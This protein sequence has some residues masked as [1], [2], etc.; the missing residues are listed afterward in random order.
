[1]PEMFANAIG[2]EQLMGRWSVRLAPLYADFAR[3]RDSGRILD[4]GCGTGALAKVVAGMTRQSEIVGVDPAQSFVDYARTQVEDR[5]VKFEVGDAMQL[6]FPTASFD[7][8]LSLLVMMFIPEPEKAA[9]EMRRVTRP[10]GTVS[11]CTW[12]RDGLELASIFW[13]EAMRLDPGAEARSQRPKHSNREG[14]LTALWQSASLE[15]VKETVLTMQLPFAS[16]NDFWDPHLRGVAPQGA[17]VAS[18]SE[19]RREALRQGLHKRLLGNRPDGAFSLRAKAL[20]VRG[21][22]PH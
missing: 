10:G 18:L 2:Y 5:R 20:A 11:A 21:T 8:T 12:D 22:V 16:F 17:Y 19:E 1:M 14:Q 6:P 7:Q 13:E 3:V 9:T 15:E 4:V